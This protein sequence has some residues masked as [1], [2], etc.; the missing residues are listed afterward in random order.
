MNSLGLMSE[1][2]SIQ[3]KPL[4][5]CPLA[6]LELD[7]CHLMAFLYDMSIHVYTVHAVSPTRPLAGLSPVLLT[8]D[9]S[10]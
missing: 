5:Q 7:A 9:T 6:S 3:N 1:N 4:W 8:A 10:H 2:L